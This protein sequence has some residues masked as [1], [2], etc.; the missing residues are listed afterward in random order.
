MPA[1]PPVKVAPTGDDAGFALRVVVTAANDD[2]SAIAASEPTAPVTGLAGPPAPAP[3]KPPAARTTHTKLRISLRDSKRHKTGTLTATITNVP[4]GREVRVATARVALPAGTWRLRL[5]AG[6]RSGRLRC[7]VGTRVTSRKRGVRLPSARAVVGGSK[8]ALRITAAAVD[9]R[10]RVRA[11][12]KAA[13][14][15]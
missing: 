6:P 9:G 14:K 1:T 15:R 11:Q 7:A 5:C 4:A 13:T 12:G 3:P 2:G 8:G 10:L